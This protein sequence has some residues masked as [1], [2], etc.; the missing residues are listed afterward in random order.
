MPLAGPV[1]LRAGVLAPV[2]VS[3]GANGVAANGASQN[4]SF[5]PD[6]RTILFESLASNLGSGDTNGQWDVFT[7]DLASGAVTRVSTS[8][9]GGQANGSSLDAHFDASGTRVVFDSSAPDLVLSGDSNGARD[10]F[11]KNLATGAVTLVS[12]APV[13][14]VGNGDS[15]LGAI[16]PDGGR[17]AFQSLATNLIGA[18]TNHASDIYIKDLASGQV[19][20]ASTDSKGGEANGQSADVAWSPDGTK[21]VFESNA[22]NLVA[23]DT[24]GSYDIFVK[25]LTTG[26]IARVS[27]A[28]DG[29]QANGHS[30]H[31]HF[32]ADGQ[33]VVFESLASN[34]VPG[35]TNGARDVFSKNL[36]TGAVTLLST[37][38][39]GGQS[40]GNS[41]APTQAA[42]WTAFESNADLA[43]GDTNARRDIYLHDDASGTDVRV[44][45]G[46]GAT[47][48]NADAFAPALAA[49]GSA[50]L[51]ESAA[52]NLVAGDTNAARDVFLAKLAPSVTTGAVTEN[53]AAA[54][55][56]LW[57]DDGNPAAAHSVSVTPP[58]GALGHLDATLAIDATGGGTGR[59][60]WRVGGDGFDA[61][62]AGETVTQ[63]WQVTVSDGA[64]HSA[65]Q[66]VT[67]T[68]TG[69][70]DAPVAAADAFHVDAGAV[71]ADLSGLLL[72][73]DRD[74][75]H[76]DMLAIGSIDTTGTLGHAAIDPVTHALTYTA[77]AT[78]F[79]GLLVGQSATDSFA[80]TVHDLAGATSTATVTVT[81]DGIVP[82]G[83][84]PLTL[85][86]A[87]G[88][89][90]VQGGDLGDTLYGGTGP[91]TLI[92]GK[93]ADTLIGGTGD[94]IY[95]VDNPGDQVIAPA[96]AGHQTVIASIDYTLPANVHELVLVGGDLNGTG[97]A[98][99]NRLSGT[100][101]NNV[102]DGGPGADMMAGGL[103]NDTYLVDNPG[104]Q[105]IE[106]PGAGNDLVRTTLAT[107]TLPD[108]VENL[109]FEGA[110]GVTGTGNASANWIVGT[111]G[112][113]VLNGLAGN[114][115]LT[116]GAG[117]DIL[118]GGPGAD[119]LRG[120]TGA[121]TFVER[122][123]EAQ[124]DTI[125]DFNTSSTG[126]TLLLAGWGAGTSVSQTGEGHW[127][128]RDGVD[129]H[130]ETLTIIGDVQP[131]DIKFG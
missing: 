98:L 25:D 74:V 37:D 51:F 17:V 70:N 46:A 126:D 114:D 63:T 125:L 59:I 94:T 69:V 1:F 29:S 102:L 4:A 12:S 127:A 89:D 76:G 95:S 82:P 119:M 86:A 38:L 64:G 26:A 23:G 67:L 68:L 122:R 18:D 35:D 91:D 10:V 120:G 124:G 80:Y 87:P 113:D 15:T 131:A 31:A 128:I 79:A 14:L 130:V 9:S 107:Y 103:G 22:S 73:N 99:D 32:S 101:G 3:F 40:N 55:G 106:A 66:P 129:G 5:S 93:G 49:D 43:G 115:Y 2:R 19:I 112:D 117:N 53:G 57:F 60:E 28:T 33:S 24:N 123:G 111:A 16:A 75:D 45:I 41:Y 109:A 118:D 85:H 116:G 100:D 83:P 88:G 78:A 110:P 62:A 81:I 90:I 54:T 58:A 11:V 6:G 34:L 42:G 20:R 96:N 7:R 108:N 105:V 8:A 77:D 65:V 97:N 50:V 72:T 56:S 36:A 47:Q 71:S 104:D 39:A 48:G 21:V 121:N 13:G 44:S 84:Q 30:F 52:S 27:T 61:L 92:G